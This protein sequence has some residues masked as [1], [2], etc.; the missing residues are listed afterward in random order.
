MQL[1]QIIKG[2]TRVTHT[3]ETLIDHIYVSDDL[4]V[5]YSYPFK[6]CTSGNFRVFQFSRICDFGTF[7]VLV[8][9]NFQL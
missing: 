6:Y 2:T 5:L 3:S 1:N 4:P 9:A 8:F 7:R